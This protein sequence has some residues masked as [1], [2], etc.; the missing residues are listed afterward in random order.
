ML[1]TIRLT[2]FTFPKLLKGNKANFRFLAALR[3][4]DRDGKPGEL[5]V[6]LPNA[7]DYW[8]CD[9][10]KNEKLNYV[11]ADRKKG[12]NEQK[13][14]PPTFDMCRVGAWNNLVF[15]VRARQLTAIQFKVFDVNRKDAWEKLLPILK[16]IPGTLAGPLG[17][18]LGIAKEA[19]SVV[20]GEI[21]QDDSLL[22]QGSLKLPYSGNGKPTVE[23]PGIM[24]DYNIQFCVEH[25]DD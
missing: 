7:V 11:R 3:F 20:V 23:G 9:P 14:P 19:T 1:H 16:A 21:S 18:A 13:D 5:D 17:P 2:G 8:E 10:K 12:V 24:G 6:I 4:V 25:S 22:F 15:Q